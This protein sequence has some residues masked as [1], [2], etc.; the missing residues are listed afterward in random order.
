MQDK[1]AGILYDL[2]ERAGIECDSTEAQ[3]VASVQSERKRHIASLK[4]D[5]T[6][7]AAFITVMELEKEADIFNERR[8]QWKS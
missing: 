3:R 7:V 4:G 2:Q 6:P 1:Y 5:M 8:D